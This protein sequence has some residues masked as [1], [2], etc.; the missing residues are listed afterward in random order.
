[1]KKALFSLLVAF[2]L[3]SG[4]S[5][6]Q[7][8]TK[9]G[10]VISVDTTV[11][12]SMTWSVNNV[13]YTGSDVVM[14]RLN[15]DTTYL[16]NLT[17][18]K[19]P[20]VDTLMNSFCSYRWHN[21]SIINDTVVVD[22]SKTK[23]GKCDSVTTIT[24][25]IHTVKR[26]TFSVVSCFDYVFAN[27]T[28]DETGFYSDT[29]RDEELGCESIR[30]LNLTM[31]YEMSRVLEV[32]NCGAYKWNLN[33]STYAESTS[34]T[35]QKPHATEKECD[36]L[37]ILVLDVYHLDDTINEVVCDSFVR[38]E[39]V[40]YVSG[41][42][43]DTTFDGVCPTHN[44]VNLTVM[45]TMARTISVEKCGPYK[46]SLKDSVYA[47]TT[48]D[49][50]FVSANGKAGVC[51]TLYTLD[52]TILHLEDT[53]T[54]AVC[55][56]YKRLD[57]VYT[58]SGTYFDTTVAS[59]GCATH[60]VLQLT[61]TPKRVSD[62]DTFVAG[63]GSLGLIF[64]N[65]NRDTLKYYDSVTKR[66][67]VVRSVYNGATFTNNSFATVRYSSNTV[68][69]CFD[70]AL[71]VHVR[72][73]KLAR[74]EEKMV[75]CDRYVWDFKEYHYD[76]VKTDSITDSISKKRTFTETGKDSVI[77]GKT[78]DGCDSFFVAAVTIHKSPVISSIEGK[79]K[80]IGDEMTRLYVVADQDDLKYTW[81]YGNK[82]KDA[83]TLKIAVT[84]N[85]DV[86]VRAT[87]KKTGCYGE[88]WIT[89]LYG[90]GIDNVESVNISLYPNPTVQTLNIGSDQALR[91]ATIYNVMGAEVI[92]QMLSGNNNA[93]NLSALPQGTYSIRVEMENG[94]SAI[95]KFVKTK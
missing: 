93:I 8:P 14:H 25:K 77:V 87:N 47:E 18:V 94:Q 85:T 38:G 37:L 51:D 82:Q 3:I 7:K 28:L 68:N 91:S 76:T 33:D 36:S 30:T 52:V 70:S 43:F 65:T 73:N 1:M 84:A 11:C 45:D 20:K 48:T 74:H 79:F 31:K 56:Q 21:F 4:V 88:S 57:T 42:Y 62:I 13:T 34:D 90:V 9:A 27:D 50:V 92:N 69:S 49:T 15:D 86:T 53:I 16:L 44:V 58:E 41:T 61:I 22:S 60:N 75:G 32:S 26:D 12:D 66:T 39:N 89:I 64:M 5:M 78:L 83:D 95:R 54:A 72:I 59:N 23:I 35:L 6:A 29:T 2:L 81:T 71:Y 67:T 24:V 40:Y 46:W 17:V 19:S 63:C 55:G 80:I 10:V